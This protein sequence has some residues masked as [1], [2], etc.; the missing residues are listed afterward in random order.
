MKQH[1]T[2]RTG[3]KAHLRR[4]QLPWRG[5]LGTTECGRPI[6]PTSKIVGGLAEYDQMV[7]DVGRGDTERA[8]CAACWQ[9]AMLN[10]PYRGEDPIIGLLSRELDRVRAISLAGE[11][12]R[13][14]A[15]LR[16][17]AQVAA[18]HP[19]AYADALDGETALGAL[20]GL[21]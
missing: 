15:E 10:K 18:D 5:G 7:A 4:P 13:L 9:A 16:A 2:N 1:R 14:V 11:R 17:L 3:A 6:D 21:R 20:A 8:V 12:V 19:D